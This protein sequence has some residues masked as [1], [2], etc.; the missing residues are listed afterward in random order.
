MTQRQLPLAFPGRMGTGRAAGSNFT[1]QSRFPGDQG[2]VLL[3]TERRWPAGH[4]LS[5]SPNRQEKRFTLI[6][7]CGVLRCYI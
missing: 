4:V 2:T 1:P 5:V 3:S 7:L 6:R